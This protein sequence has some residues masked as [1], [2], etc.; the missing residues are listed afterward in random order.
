MTKLGII[1][2][3]DI[4][5]ALLKEKMENMTVTAQAGMEF[6]EGKPILYSLGNFWFNH[7]EL[8]TMLVEVRITGERDN[9]Q[10]EVAVIP[11]LQ[12]NYKTTI[13][14]EQEEKEELYEYLE[15]ISIN[16]EIDENGVVTE[17]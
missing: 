1:G 10:I 16:V 4:E 17:K 8:D 9:P 7:K 5:V 15:S 2:A 3:M 11:A 14:T 6:Y 13:L 12:K